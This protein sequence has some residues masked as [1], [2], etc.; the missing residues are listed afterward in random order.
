MKIIFLFSQFLFSQFIF[1]QLNDPTQPIDVLMLKQEGQLVTVQI[2][3]GEPIRIF[4]VGKEEAKIN[5]NDMKLTVR[6]LNPYPGKILNVTKSGDYFSVSEPTPTDHPT[7]L[8]IKTK[9]KNKKEETFHFKL[10][11]KPR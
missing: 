7:E 11:N 5:L 10:N 1:A 2:A 8:E 4:V 9:I 6:R 3:I